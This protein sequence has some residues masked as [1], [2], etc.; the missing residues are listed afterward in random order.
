M[1]NII[2]VH[3]TYNVNNSKTG[4]S[5]CPVVPT[6]GDLCNSILKFESGSWEWVANMSNWRYGQHSVT[7]VNL[8][9]IG[10]DCN[11]NGK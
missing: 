9:E 1:I 6:V 11:A 10:F 3:I 7:S 4:G 2:Y 5:G 8:E